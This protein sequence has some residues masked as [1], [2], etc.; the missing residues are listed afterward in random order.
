MTMT[1]ADFNSAAEADVT[2][3]LLRCCGCADWA[4]RVQARRPYSSVQALQA[5][6][7]V[8]WFSLSA[9]HWREG[10]SAHPR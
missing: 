2:A 4:A 8:E 1:L 5:R 9:D 6:G 7:A 10:F 3:A